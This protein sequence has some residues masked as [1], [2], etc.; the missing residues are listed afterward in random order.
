[1]RFGLMLRHLG[2]QP[3]GIGTYTKRLVPTMLERFPQHRFVLFYDHPSRLGTFAQFPNAEEVAVRIG[4]KLLWDQLAVPLLARRHRVDA[5]LNLKASVPLLSSS[6]SAFIFPG[7]DWFAFPTQY[8]LHDRLY[9]RV[10]AGLYCR[11]AAAVISVSH[12]SAGIIAEH[13]PAARGK[14]HTVY[15]AVSAA[16]TAAR[17]AEELAAFR[18]RYGLPEHF[19]LYLGQIY[20]MKNVSGII[21]AF[22]A[23]RDR[24]PHKLVLVGKLHPWAP[25]ELSLIEELGLGDSVLHVGYVPDEDVPLFYNLADVFVFPSLF[26][27]FGMPILEAMASGCPVVTSTAGACPEV[28]GDAAL[29]VDPRNVGAIARAIQQAATDTE[30]R[31]T[32]RARGLARVH[33]FSWQ[34]AADQTV[35]LLEQ[36]ADDGHRAAARPEAQ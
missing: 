28:A 16:F 8:P 35:R 9:A 23:I 20:P 18:H 21:R 6:P 34:A 22:A 24:I 25:N 19:L 30:L 15:H 14:L 1:M 2:R 13:M 27:G 5:L 10:F 7:A 4:A 33:R 32:M 12:D 17:P 26:E 36:I 31:A 3:G 29:L 11:K